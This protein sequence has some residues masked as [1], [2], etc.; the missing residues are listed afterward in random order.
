MYDVYDLPDEWK[1][2]F[3]GVMGVD[4]LHDLPRPLDAVKMF[5]K[6]LRVGGFLSILDIPANGRIADNIGND[7]AAPFYI[8]SL[9]HCVPLALSAGGMAAGAMWGRE[10]VLECLKQAGFEEVLE[11]QGELSHR[12]GLAFYVAWKRQ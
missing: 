1:G 9:Y 5:R 3:D 4:I 12:G 8:M 7:M 11:P 2:S 6:M 10:N